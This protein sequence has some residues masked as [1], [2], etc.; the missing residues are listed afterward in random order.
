[1]QQQ[2][3]RDMADQDDQYFSNAFRIRPIDPSNIDC[4]LDSGVMPIVAAET[5][6][7][8][9]IAHWTS[10]TSRSSERLVYRE[11]SKFRLKAAPSETQAIL[12]LFGRSW[13]GGI[14]DNS[15]HHG[16]AVRL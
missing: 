9:S 10:K 4:D 1:M 12:G 14:W 13:P 11:I 2:N 3:A 15:M 5:N 6:K 7:A 16:A 8:P